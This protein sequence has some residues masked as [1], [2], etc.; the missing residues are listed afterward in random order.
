ME[1]ITNRLSKSIQLYKLESGNFDTDS[2][3]IVIN[4]LLFDQLK[5][6]DIDSKYIQTKIIWKRKSGIKFRG[7]GVGKVQETIY[8]F[9]DIKLHPTDKVIENEF[10]IINK[11]E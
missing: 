7:G 5:I 11:N 3:I 1:K 6:E 9:R 2:I 8:Y 10:I 4:F